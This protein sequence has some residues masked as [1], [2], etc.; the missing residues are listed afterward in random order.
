MAGISNRKELFKSWQKPPSET[1]DQKSEALKK[2]VRRAIDA[3]EKLKEHSTSVQVHGSYAS[4]TNVRNNSDIDIQVVFTNLYN[5]DYSGVDGL[6]NTDVGLSPTDYSMAQARADVYA[7]LRAYFGADR[8]SDKD[9]AIHIDPSGSHQDADV[10]AC[11]R[12]RRYFGTKQNL[13]YH[14]G[15][16]FVT[17]GGTQITNWPK[18]NIDNGNQKAAST[19]RRYKKVVRILKR[20]NIHMED[21]GSSLAKQFSSYF[22]ESL[23][24][25]VPNGQ[26]GHQE[27]DDDV[28]EALAF[29]FH[30]MDKDE[31]N[32][33]GEVNEL[34][35]LFR[36]S[37]PTRQQTKTW[38]K[39]AWNYCGYS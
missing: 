27:I 6:Q 28:R 25:N 36:G 33:W 32:E 3:S 30:A 2:A 12:H 35:Y 22:I 14:E 7:A 5:N 8:V 38:A 21:N 11:F 15:V 31:S 23:V 4:N 34:T 26:F 1:E 29:L 20:L 18:Q 10:I 24:W 9:K 19:K 13:R 39:E 37:K 16:R 17:K